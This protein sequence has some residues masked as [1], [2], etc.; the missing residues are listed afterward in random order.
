MSCSTDSVT[1][2]IFN[3]IL[4]DSSTQWTSMPLP[5]SKNEGE[6]PYFH[7][8]SISL[9]HLISL[10][11]VALPEHC[12]LETGRDYCK[13]DRRDSPFYL[14]V[15]WSKHDPLPV[16][17][18]VW[19]GSFAVLRGVVHSSVYCT[20]FN[21]IRCENHRVSIE[22][23]GVIFMVSNFNFVATGWK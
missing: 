23:L 3:F 7:V 8:W 17:M 20:V 16:L 6:A 12:P 22:D 13:I 5:A 4:P 1:N 11:V 15:L 21:Q 19:N 14:P 9:G 10:F 2:I 18:A